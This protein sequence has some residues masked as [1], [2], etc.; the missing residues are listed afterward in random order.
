LRGF[1]ESFLNGSV[2]TGSM[3][4]NLMICWPDGMTPVR[5]I[6]G[7]LKNTNKIKTTVVVF[8]ENRK[9]CDWILGVVVRRYM[10]LVELRGR[11]GFAFGIKDQG[12]VRVMRRSKNNKKSSNR[13]PE[14]LLVCVREC[15][16][17]CSKNNCSILFDKCCF[18]IK[19]TSKL[20]QFRDSK[21]SVGCS[22]FNMADFEIE[23]ENFDVDVVEIADE[24]VLA[25]EEPP[26]IKKY[27]LIGAHN[28]NI[29]Y[30]IC[31]GG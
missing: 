1:S 28:K 12:L 10:G 31:A 24:Y 2:E 17:F 29:L 9:K 20:H 30:M 6:Y 7:N 14:C 16:L 11:V 8:D 19:V 22:N 5:S 15:H 26:A 4:P 25:E 13:V 21:L 23:F 3:R 18:K 27:A